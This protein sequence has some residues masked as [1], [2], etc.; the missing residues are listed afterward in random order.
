MLASPSGAPAY[1]SP[2]AHVRAH[3]APAAWTRGAHCE[4]QSS[5]QT[6]VSF[7]RQ[8]WTQPSAHSGSSAVWP[9]SWITKAKP[10]PPRIWQSASCDSGR[11]AWSPPSGPW[12]VRLWRSSLKWKEVAKPW[13]TTFFSRYHAAPTRSDSAGVSRSCFLHIASEWSKRGGGGS[14]VRLATHDWTHRSN[15]SVSGTQIL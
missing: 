13:R 15:G 7:A 1:G 8:F 2:A 14:Y 11:V 10:S 5:K 6:A 3:A 12:H 4:R 9:A